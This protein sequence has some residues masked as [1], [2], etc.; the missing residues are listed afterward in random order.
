MSDISQEHYLLCDELTAAERAY[1]AGWPVMEDPAYDDLLRKLIELERQHPDLVTPAS[2]TQRV[3]A[4]RLGGFKT[5]AHVERMLSLDNCYT[6]DDLCA[7]IAK[8][9]T[10]LNDKVLSDWVWCVEPKIDGL[11]LEIVYENGVLVRAVTR[12]DGEQGEDVTVNVRTIRSVPLQIRG[13][14]PGTFTVRGEVYLPI[15]EFDRQNEVLKANGGEPYANP[16][17]AAVGALKLRDPKEV[18]QRRLAFLAYGVT[19]AG[20]PLRAQDESLRYLSTLGFSCPIFFTC[21]S[22]NVCAVVQE[23]DNRRPSLDYLTD[24]TVVKLNPIEFRAQ[25]GETSK[26][27]RWAVACKFGSKTMTTVLNS[28]TV[29]VGKTGTLAPVAELEGVLLNGTTIRRASLHNFDEIDRLGLKNG[30]LVEIAKAGEIIPHLIRVAEHRSGTSIWKPKKCP[31]CGTPVVQDR[32]TLLCPNVTGCSPQV[33]GRLEHWC[34]KGAMDIDGG[35]E[36]MVKNLVAN[37]IAS[38]PGELYGI[39][40]SDLTDASIGIKTASKF[41]EGIAKSKTQGLERVLYGLSIPFVGEGTAKRLAARFGD[42]ARIQSAS[43]EELSRVEDIGETTASA[44]VSWF[45]QAVNQN[46]VESLKGAGVVMIA[47]KAPVKTGKL[48]GHVVV[49]T[50][51]LELG[52]REAAWRLIEDAGGVVGK[53]VNKKTTLLLVGED[54]GSKVDKAKKAGAKIVYEQDFLNM[55]K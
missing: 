28:V 20:Q 21:I 22:T 31:S 38:H 52:P 5:V 10:A 7:F 50:G 34:S 11:A 23:M 33:E 13:H 29:Q 44:I 51:T 2:P 8:I 43:V 39:E 24:G 3:G 32:S 9:R 40:L 47:H 27:P 42:M 48:S 4:G 55:I 54:P 1:Y 16:R 19:Y 46:L 18:N 15:S 6:P 12:G 30:D 14:V 41:L 26:F 45:S 36:V 53:D 35:G 37:G 17:N 49:V 25:F